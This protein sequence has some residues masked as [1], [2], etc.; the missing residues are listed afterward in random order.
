MAAGCG[1]CGKPKPK[2]HGHPSN[3]SSRPVNQAGTS[4]AAQT[5]SFKLTLGSGESLTVRGSLL[6]AQ[7]TLQRMGGSGTIEM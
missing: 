4:M 2:P 1:S 7:A 3:A 5:Q 6:E